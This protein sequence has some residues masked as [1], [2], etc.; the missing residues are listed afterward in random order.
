MSFPEIP[1]FDLRLE[2]EDVQAVLDVLRSGWLT[3]GPKTAEFEAAFAEH[4][5]AKHAVAVSSCTAALHLAYLAAGVGPGDEVIVPAMTFAATASAAIYC[6]ATPVFA[7]IA[8]P[9]ELSL[10]VLVER[11][12]RRVDVLGFGRHA[13]NDRS[14]S[15][16][17]DDPLQELLRPLRPR[18][19]EDL[20]RRALLEDRSRI[21]EADAVCDVACERHLV[22]RDHHR[23]AS[24]RQFADH[25]E[26]IGHELGVECAR[27]LVE[28]H[29]LGLHRERAHDR[30][31]L[32]LAAREPV[33]EL[34]ALVLEPESLQQRC[35]LLLGLA[36]E[37]A[38]APCAGR[39]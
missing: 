16:R 23:H 2:E 13:R 17:I 27:D 6:G 10:D 3:M 25:V 37:T 24:E 7:E 11:L 14:E 18:R 1:L 19:A 28:E 33:G 31:A 9:H 35:R 5:G 22:R 29:Q 32:L 12:E 4:L 39:G 21:Q 8:G 38:P 36:R 34:V 20:L 15:A 26:D 30:D